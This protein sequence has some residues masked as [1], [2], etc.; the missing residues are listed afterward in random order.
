MLHRTGDLCTLC[1][2]R[3][4]RSGSGAAHLPV[5]TVIS[6]PLNGFNSTAVLSKGVLTGIELG[7]LSCFVPR[8]QSTAASTIRPQSRR[9]KKC[10]GKMELLE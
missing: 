4:G 2:A 9:I 1:S 10:Q 3:G 6:I 8:I 7:Q 5:K